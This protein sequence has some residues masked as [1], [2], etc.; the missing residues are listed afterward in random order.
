MSGLKKALERAGV[1]VDDIEK[2]SSF[3][4][5]AGGAIEQI[6][7]NMGALSEDQLP[8]LYSD[9]LGEPIVD[10]ALID[11]WEPSDLGFTMRQIEFLSERGWLPLKKSG[12]GT[13]VFCTRSPLDL[14]AIEF[15]TRLEAETERL[16]CDRDMFDRL[17]AQF[18]AATVGAVATLTNQLST[19]EEDRLRELAS[20]APTVNLLNRLIARALKMRASDIHIEPSE[21][22]VLVRYRIDGV[23]QD[24]ESV[25]L[26]LQLPLVSRVKILAGMDIA[27]RRRPQDG[28]IELRISNT[29]LDIRV[30]ALP[31][32]SGEHLLAGQGSGRLRRRA[33]IS[34]MSSLATRALDTVARGSFLSSV[35]SR[36][37][38]PYLLRLSS[39]AQRPRRLTASG[40]RRRW[41][42]SSDAPPCRSP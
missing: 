35:S 6:L 19:T 32:Q 24:A 23:L 42:R 11:S 27:E 15:V 1:K 20:E 28:K 9:A 3:Q 36:V 2:A 7:V 29:D 13:I 5:R 14:E 40:V 17:V 31:L 26:R 12:S 38:F 39:D 22:S 25:P 18:D 16:I 34:W 21:Q 4:Q 33:R 10:R 30:S 37:S 8:L 41:R